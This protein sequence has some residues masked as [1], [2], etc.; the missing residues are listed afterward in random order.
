MPTAI[1]D[2]KYKVSDHWRMP[3]GGLCISLGV[4]AY[5]EERGIAQMLDSLFEQSIFSGDGRQRMGV[6]RLELICV[7]NGC[8]DRTAEVALAAFEARSLSNEI[9]LSVRSCAQAGK[10]RAW[11]K[12]VH[13]FS[14]QQ[15]DY[16]ILLDAD[17]AFASPD[18]LEKMIQRLQDMPSALVS[19]DTPIKGV[20]LRKARLSL[21]DRAS[22]SASAQSPI[23]NAITGQLYCA[24]GDELRRIWMPLSLPVEDGFLAAM[25]YTNGFTVQERPEAI[26]RVEEAIHYY[27]A[28]EDIAGFLR[29]ESRIVVGSVI[30]AWIF[31]LLWVK[32]SDGHVG[33][34]ILQ[35]NMANPNWLDELI[36]GEVARRGIWLVP[37]GFIFKRLHALR[38]VPLM[39]ALRRLPVAFIATALQLV[40]CVRANATLKSS[41]PSS[42]W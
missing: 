7:P 27:D 19:T 15:A 28:H 26:T 13:E 40:A 35:E 42:F 10:A 38:G 1:A 6:D 39:T 5:N 9:R 23:N 25:I 30:N 8:T 3:K 20:K 14:N 34:Y 21:R 32:G 16:L 41:R 31:S 17:I 24:R 37:S 18:I 36:A 2:E 33:R 29:H 4:L 22:L 11:N 12:F